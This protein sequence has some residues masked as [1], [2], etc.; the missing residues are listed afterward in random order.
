MLRKSHHASVGGGT[1]FA[2]GE[3]KKVEWRVLRNVGEE[4]MGMEGRVGG[5]VGCCVWVC[6]YAGV[7]GV[8]KLQK[9]WGWRGVD[10][11]D[12]RTHLDDGVL[13]GA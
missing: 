7:S 6:V 12:F 4:V 10:K 5:G 2:V 8:V 13:S 11:G 1:E 9:R 3:G